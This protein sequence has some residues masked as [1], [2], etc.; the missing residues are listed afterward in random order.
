MPFKT[1]S[2]WWQRNT[3]DSESFLSSH[4]VAL[5]A[6]AAFRYC[7]NNDCPTRKTHER[8]I[9]SMKKTRQID[10][11]CWR[12]TRQ[13]HDGQKSTF[14]KRCLSFLKF[15][16]VLDISF[17]LTANRV[18]QRTPDTSFNR[19][20]W[21]QVR[22]SYTAD[23][24]DCSDATIGRFNSEESSSFPL[25]DPE[26]TW[27]CWGLQTDFPWMQHYNFTRL[28]WISDILSMSTTPQ[29]SRPRSAKASLKA[30]VQ[31]KFSSLPPP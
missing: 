6:W 20:D 14:G 17:S 5:Q 16:Y 2:L 28:Q 29:I 9:S 24:R 15:I 19:I 10:L 7:R 13:T 23:F 25:Y 27:T 22:Q 21:L 31:T 18:G 26:I 4:V 8:P 1:P 3:W 30:P 12:H 11:L